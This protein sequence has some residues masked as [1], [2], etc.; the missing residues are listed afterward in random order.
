MTMFRTKQRQ[1]WIAALTVGLIGFAIGAALQAQAQGQEIGAPTVAAPVAQVPVASS[2]P[3]ASTM[4]TPAVSVAPTPVASVA[5]TP[6]QPDQTLA[7]AIASY[8]ATNTEVPTFTL[9]DQQIVG[10]TARVL[11]V[12]PADVADQAFAF[13]RKGADGWEVISIGTWFPQEF[14]QSENIPAELWVQ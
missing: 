7:A 13:A 2:A 8:M 12:P 5:P 14:Y 4:P 9:K 1:R 3:V 10:D 11:L 6:T